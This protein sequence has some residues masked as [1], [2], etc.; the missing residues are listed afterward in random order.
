MSPEI[1]AAKP[2]SAS[3]NGR[4]RSIR[5]RT[6]VCSRKV[7]SRASWSRLPMVEPTTDSC[8]KNTRFSSAGGAA[9][10]VA[11][12]MTILPPGRSAFS[13]WLHVALG[14]DLAPFYYGACGFR[15]TP[16]GLIHLPTL[17]EAR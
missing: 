6:P 14:E 13:E 10:L 8:R 17:P 3:V 16:A 15:P 12:A 11:P 1:I 2:A 5:G 7:A 9:P 4:L